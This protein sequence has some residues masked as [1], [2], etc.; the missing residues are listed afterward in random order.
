MANED[1][2]CAWFQTSAAKYEGWLI[3]TVSYRVVSFVVGG[4]KRSRMRSVVD[5]VLHSC[6]VSIQST[7]PLSSSAG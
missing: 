6:L 4:K 5:S 7:K 1:E 2:S 3:S